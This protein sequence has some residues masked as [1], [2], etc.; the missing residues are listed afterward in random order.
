MQRPTQ[1]RSR[2]QRA[3]LRCAQCG[4]DPEAYAGSTDTGL[5]GHMEQERGSQPLVQESVA[6]LRQLDRAA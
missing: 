3:Y 5:M 1:Q 2:H 6:Q 4:A